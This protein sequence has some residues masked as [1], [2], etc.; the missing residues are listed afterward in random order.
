MGPLALAADHLDSESVKKDP[1]ADITDIYAWTEGKKVLLVLNV[2]PLATTDSK[3][4]NAVQYAMHVESSAKFGEAGQSTDVICTFDADQKISCWIG[5]DD[6][7][8]GDASNT[9]GLASDSGKVKVFAGLRA[10]PFYFNLGG[11]N[12]AVSFVK[13]AGA[14]PADGAGC[15]TLDANTAGAIVNLLQS[16]N[17]GQGAA[18]NFFETVNVLSIVMEVDA[19]LLTGGGPILAIWGSTHTAGG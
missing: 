3:F 16:T 19:S 4:S 1:A 9:A 2:S 8:T 18:E 10:D 7:V 15:P 14:L 17:G 5:A 11:F 12:D 6:Y 13:G